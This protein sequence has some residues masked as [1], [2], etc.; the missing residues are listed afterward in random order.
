MRKYSKDDIILIIKETIRNNVVIDIDNDTA[1]MDCNDID[2]IAEEIA[3]KI[4]EE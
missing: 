2:H 1:S 4:K 3:N